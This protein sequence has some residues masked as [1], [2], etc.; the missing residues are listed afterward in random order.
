[1]MDHLMSTI[2]QNAR[3][4]APKDRISILGDHTCHKF[5][6]H[7]DIRSQELTTEDDTYANTPR[8][9]ATPHIW[10][11]PFQSRR[12]ERGNLTFVSRPTSSSPLLFRYIVK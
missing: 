1:M 9:T 3:T 7:E 8:Q 2:M 12:E 6:V 5:I 4:A 11:L 10:Q